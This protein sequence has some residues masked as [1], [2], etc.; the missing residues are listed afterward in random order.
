MALFQHLLGQEDTTLK[1]KPILKKEHVLKASM[2]SG[3]EISTPKASSKKRLFKELLEIIQDLSDP[4]W[5]TPDDLNISLRSLETSSDSEDSSQSE[6]EVLP[7]PPDPPLE[8]GV[9]K[10][11]KFTYVPFCAAHAYDCPQNQ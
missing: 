11:S 1:P 3:P 9:K 7:T 5:E 2:I 4:N 10:K 8:G 6:W